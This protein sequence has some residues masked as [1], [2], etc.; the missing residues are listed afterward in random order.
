M[1]GIVWK[2]Q[3]RPVFA[4]RDTA[5][6]HKRRLVGRIRVLIRSLCDVEI[7]DSTTTDFLSEKSISEID[8]TMT[9]AVI[10]RTHGTC[11]VI[12]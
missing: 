10:L 2:L 12:K 5:T 3:G 9:G 11:A 6:C 4:L 8:K 7:S 1:S